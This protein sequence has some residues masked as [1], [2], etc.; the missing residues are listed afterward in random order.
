MLEQFDAIIIVDAMDNL[1]R[2]DDRLILDILEE[3]LFPVGHVWITLG[4]KPLGL[5]SL[6]A[7]LRK[8]TRGDWGVTVGEDADRNKYL[9]LDTLNP[10]GK[11][12]G[13]VHSA[14]PIDPEKPCLGYGDNCIWVISELH[15][16]KTTLLL[17]EEY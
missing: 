13:T 14:Y 7:C 15:Y 6:K 9:A 10:R 2:L 16:G 4:V 11:R 1:E 17:P 3:T 8:H 12:A 5:A